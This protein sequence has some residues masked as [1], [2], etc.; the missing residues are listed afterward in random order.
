L[1]HHL[2][3]LSNGFDLRTDAVVVGSG[4]GGAMAA[5]NL[6]TAGLKTVV[7]EA[8]PQVTAREMTRDAPLFMARYF[9]EGGLRI[10]GGSAQIPTMQ[11]RCL[12]GSTLVNSAI[13]LKLPEWIRRA[14]AREDNLPFILDSEVDDAFARVFALTG[15]APTPLAVMGRRNE[16][17]RDALTAAGIASGPLPRAVVGCDGCAD[18]LTG[19]TEGR[20]QSVDRSVL[21]QAERDG[22]EVY[23]CAV[24]DRVL[25][26]GT[27][28]VGV[29]GQV[30][31]PQGMRALA[32]FTVRA[33]LVLLGA[34]VMA[35]PVILLQSGIKGRVG[36]TLYAHLGGGVT[37]IMDEVVDPWVGA[38]QGWGAISDTIPGMKFE[39]LWAPTAVIAVRW[40]GMGEEFL[41]RL[42]EIKRATV[43]CCVYR[44]EVRGSVRAKRNGMPRMRLW[45]PQREM[46]V[47]LRGMKILAD[48]FLKVGANYAYAGVPGTKDE[49][50]TA[51]DTEALL[52]PRLG[53]RDVPMTANHVFGSCRMS[54]DPKRGVVDANGKVYGVEGLYI[55]DSSIFPSPSAVNPQA[56]VMVLADLISRKLGELGPGGGG[57]TPPAA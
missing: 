29:S 40:G 13:M 30:V 2:R 9:W 22:A 16:I 1:I 34:G 11:G 41:R 55:V 23:T 24:V 3:D 26:E 8:G 45:I 25:T 15:T 37:G 46:Q 20:K 32:P 14:W 51:R 18:C 21:P 50:R 54:A 35:T 52:N 12:G 53:A 4:A 43:A 19:C 42:Q 44:A 38:T 31:D 28:V 33:P 36:K 56:T 49:M 39:S 57:S 10:L 5:A 6:A 17:V 47:V 7:L 27:R 48:A